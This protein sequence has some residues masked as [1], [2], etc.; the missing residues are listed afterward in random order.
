MRSRGRMVKSASSRNSIGEIFGHIKRLRHLQVIVAI[1]IITFIVDVLVEF[2][3]SAFAKNLFDKRAEVD[4]ISSDQDPLARIT[5]RPR[6]V[7]VG[8]SYKF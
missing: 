6:T 7:G 8:L 2:Q 3:F 5:V 1:I 4:A